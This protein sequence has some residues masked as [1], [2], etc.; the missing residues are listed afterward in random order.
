MT[1]TMTLIGGPMVLIEAAG[2]RLVTDP[3]FDAPGEYQ[4]SYVTL[5]KTSGQALAALGL[6]LRLQML[7]PGIATA[8]EFATRP[9]RGRQSRSASRTGDRPQDEAGRR[10]RQRAAR[11]RHLLSHLSYLAQLDY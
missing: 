9:C 4:L 10:D 3:T 8:I 2:F 6:R 1:L 5:A 11:R 7:E